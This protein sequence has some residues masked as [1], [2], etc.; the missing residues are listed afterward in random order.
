VTERLVGLL[1]GGPGAVAQARAIYEGG[2]PAAVRAP[3]TD[4]VDV[5]P[6]ERTQVLLED[7]DVVGLT[8]VRD[9]AD[10]GL[11]FLRY[12]VV[13]AERRGQGT[14]GRLW[15]ALSGDL[16]GRGTTRLLLDVED[17]ADPAA[18]DAERT[19]RLR[20]IR[21]YRRL[22]AELVELDPAYSPPPH[23]QPGTEAIPLRL[24]ATTID[25]SGRTSPLPPR[26][27]EVPGLAAAVM[28]HRY[29]VVR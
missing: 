16:A 21:F 5:A 22:G 23:G 19:I 15:Q 29:G 28:R 20:R 18:D 8:L 6:G 10:T 4:L 14:G 11:A 9:L 17:P 3:F 26:S 13:T 7:S 25:R 2:F 27:T 24:L 12:F 1:A